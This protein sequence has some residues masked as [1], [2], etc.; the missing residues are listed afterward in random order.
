MPQSGALIGLEFGQQYAPVVLQSVGLAGFGAHIGR[1]ARATQEAETT[2]L[3]YKLTHTAPLKSAADRHM[4]VADRER[5]TNR[6]WRQ[7][8]PPRHLI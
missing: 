6:A 8:A 4:S 3:T 2:I 7:V 1:F 5:R